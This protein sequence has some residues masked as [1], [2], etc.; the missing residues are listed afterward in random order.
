MIDDGFGGIRLIESAHCLV[1]AWRDDVRRGRFHGRVRT[2]NGRLR[3]VAY[4]RPRPGR[5]RVACR[6]PDPNIYEMRLPAL[7]FDPM[8]KGERVYLA[9]PATAGELRRRLATR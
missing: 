7:S 2:R 9:H 8:A 6:V 1:D 4:G 5:Y 3:R